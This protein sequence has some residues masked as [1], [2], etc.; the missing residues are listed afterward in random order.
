MLGFLGK[1]ESAEYQGAV[2]LNLLSFT[3]EALILQYC[4]KFRNRTLWHSG[5]KVRFKMLAT[6]YTSDC[7][8]GAWQHKHQ[9]TLPGYT[10]SNTW[11]FQGVGNVLDVIF[12]PDF[13]MLNELMI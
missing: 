7:T 4:P 6:H 1:H 11:F 2:C 8:V 10:F 9:I 13:V 5:Q 12:I 3:P